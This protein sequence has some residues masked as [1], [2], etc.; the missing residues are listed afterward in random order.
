[1]GRDRPETVGPGVCSLFNVRSVTSSGCSPTNFGSPGLD[2]SVGD[3]LLS[4]GRPIL[5]EVRCESRV[6]SGDLTRPSVR[7]NFPGTEGT[8]SP[9]VSRVRVKRVEMSDDP[10]SHRPPLSLGL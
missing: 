1:M 2:V 10:R 9:P 7:S 6:G 5:G 4:L 3:Q 8:W